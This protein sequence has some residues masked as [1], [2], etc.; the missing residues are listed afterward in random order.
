MHICVRVIT[1]IHTSIHIHTHTYIHACMHACVRAYIHTYIHAYTRLRFAL[2]ALLAS[3][4]HC[5]ACLPPTISHT[6]SAQG[7]LSQGFLSVGLLRTLIQACFCVKGAPHPAPQHGAPKERGMQ[8]WHAGALRA[9]GTRPTGL[10]DPWGRLVSL[11]PAGRKREEGR[12]GCRTRFKGAVASSRSKRTNAPGTSTHTKMP[13]ASTRTPSQLAASAC[14]A[15]WTTSDVITVTCMPR[16]R[17]S[18]AVLLSH[19]CHTPSAYSHGCGGAWSIQ[20]AASGQRAQRPAGRQLCPTALSFNRQL[21]LSKTELSALLAGGW[22]LCAL[23]RCCMLDAPCS[24]E[25]DSWML[26]SEEEQPCV[27]GCACL[28][29][30]SH[31][32]SVCASRLM[33]ARTPAA[34][35]T[36]AAHACSPS[37]RTPYLSHPCMLRPT[38]SHHHLQ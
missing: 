7:L 17:E 19:C 27:P 9:S 21:C 20:H 36:P 16:Q 31:A 18:V 37:L 1:R 34:H 13:H 15:S 8:A 26:T 11:I 5:L 10:P 28:P 35:G 29:S 32:L 14:P 30:Q 23:T 6:R 12:R 22:P 25:C 33:H 38:A 24:K 2:P 3:T 4:L